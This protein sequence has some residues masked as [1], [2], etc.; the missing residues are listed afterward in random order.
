MLR[1]ENAAPRAENAVL[2]ARVRE[3]EARLGWDLSNSLRPLS[4]DPQH[5]PAKPDLRPSQRK[6]GGQPGQHRAYRAL[7]TVEQ[8]DEIVAVVPECYR[9]CQ[10][11]VPVS[12]GPRLGRD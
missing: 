6:R 10:Q 7:L 1:L 8:M 2:Q 9:H 3:L 4:L 5:V 11:P 12:A